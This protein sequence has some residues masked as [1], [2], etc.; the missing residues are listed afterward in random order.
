MKWGK[1]HKGI[2][3]GTPKYL[4]PNRIARIAGL[5]KYPCK[6]AKGDHSWTAVKYKTWWKG[7]GRFGQQHCL[8]CGKKAYFFEK[9]KTN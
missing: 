5:R 6:K 7:E 3:W 1:K 4:Q 9:L 2:E 8:V